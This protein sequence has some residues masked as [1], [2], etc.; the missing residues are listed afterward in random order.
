MFVIPSKDT[1]KF[2]VDNASMSRGNIYATYNIMLDAD[3][4]KIKLNPPMASVFTSGDTADFANPT[5]MITAINPIGTSSL[6]IL[7]T[8]GW[9]GVWVSGLTGGTYQKL[10]GTNSPQTATDAS[11]D[12]CMFLGAGD[13]EQ[14]VVSTN[15]GIHHNSPTSIQG[16]WA[17]EAISGSTPTFTLIPFSE[18]NR[19]YLVQKK[20]IISMDT[21]YTLASTGA[22]TQV[23]GL[24]NITC[25]RASSKAI[26]YAQSGLYSGDKSKIYEWDGVATNPTAIYVISTPFIL[27]ITI[28][29]DLPVAI[30][31]RGRLW[32]YDGYTF[33]LKDGV[34]IPVREDY[35]ASQVINVHRNGMITDKGKIFILVGSNYSTLNTTERGLCGIW[36][37]DPDIGL[38]HYSSPNGLSHIYTPLVLAKTLGE[39]TYAAGFKGYITDTST[40]LSIFSGWTGIRDEGLVRTGFITTQ[41]LESKNL[42]DMFA[43]IGIK[44]RKMID[45]AAKIEV[46][47]RTWKN[48]ECNAQITWTSTTTF[49][50]S[51]IILNGTGGS[52]YC[53]P[54][55]IGDE[56]MVQD[57][58][59]CGLIAQITARSDAGGTA[60]CTIDRTA[61][62]GTGTS[63]AM[64]SNYKLLK[65]IT[66]DGS[67]FK[68]IALGIPATMLQ[69]KLVMQWREYYDE[70]QEILIPEKKQES[71]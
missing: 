51:T 30:D 64:F 69:V 55:A 49:T 37:Y 5:G 39:N 21:T 26:W 70:V 43:S 66:N 6:Y 42:T 54:V 34:N 32:F 59:N 33:K 46:K 16:V 53:T 1:K 40:E 57:G 14:I 47:Y 68:N 71:N 28:L 41:F 20:K 18:T 48:I 50:A 44:F 4:G 60:T 29:D 25:A 13:S 24:F 67:T 35:V 63:Y 65:T 9:R 7:T 31:G 8:E 52:A 17:L 22:Y 10:S 15:R 36:C 58:T 11:S 45:T 19:L 23:N 12:I 61:T 27:A 56:V 38:Y 2:V 62:L 3:V